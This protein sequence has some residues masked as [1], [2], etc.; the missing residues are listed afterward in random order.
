MN[1]LETLKSALTSQVYFVSGIDTD[2]GKSIVTG[3]LAC[4]LLRTGRRVATIKPVQTGSVE[5]S[6]DIEVHRQLMGVSL[7]EDADG[8]TAP[9]IFSYPASPHLAADLDGKTIDFER[10]S[11][12]IESLKT[13]YDTVLIEGAGGLMVPLTR[14]VL[15][16]DWIR[17]NRWPVVFVCSG[18]LGSINHTL[19]SLEAMKNRKIELAAVVWNDFCPARDNV[20]HN[21]TKNF[22]QQWVSTNWPKTLW[23]ECHD[24]NL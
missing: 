8:T 16:I 4:Q 5:V 21:D 23:L 11:S 3:R 20:I 17:Q 19:L 18:R 13:K 6:P 14:T 15:T 1:R 22:L 12:C 10:I 9:Q 2:V 7:P 24:L